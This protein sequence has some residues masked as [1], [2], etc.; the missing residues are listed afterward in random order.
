M[1]N[2]EKT[3]I[4]TLQALEKQTDKN[5]E[6]IVIDDGSIDSSFE[7]VYVFKKNSDM[8]M[9]LLKQE[10]SGPAKARNAGIEHSKGNIVIFLDSDC[11]PQYNW[12]EEMIRPINDTIVGCNC[13]YIVKNKESIVARYVDYEIAKRHEKLIGKDINTIGTYSASFTKRVLIEIGGFDV[14]YRMA[15]G[16]DFDLAFNIKKLGYNLVFTDQTFVYHI[17]P[18]SLRKYLRQQFWRGYWRV[19]VY[20]RNNDK[21][22]K[23][24]S[25]TGYEP[26]IQFILSCFSLLSIPMLFFNPILTLFG[27]GLLLL[28][29]I[30]FGICAY[31]IERKFLIVAPL[32]ASMRSIAGTFGALKYCVEKGYKEI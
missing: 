4:G 7:A 10:N 31:K 16:E 5:F 22:I 3:V 27:I 13:G 29:N 26:Q 30:R 21:I 23:G 17:H 8:Q 6:I 19:R 14:N 9:T 18:D 24:D 28:S 1:F 12:V 20:I 15:S 11:I 2:S 25:Y 32:F